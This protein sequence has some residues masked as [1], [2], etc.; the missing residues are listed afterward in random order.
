MLFPNQPSRNKSSVLTNRRVR[1]NEAGGPRGSMQPLEVGGLLPPPPPKPD[2]K[3]KSTPRSSEKGGEGQVIIPNSPMKNQ[4]KYNMKNHEKQSVSL[5]KLPSL[6]GDDVDQSEDEESQN[7]DA[8]FEA[9][10]LGN[11]RKQAGLPDLPDDGLP[12]ASATKMMI[13]DGSINRLVNQP[14]VNL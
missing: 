14:I 8:D 11:L 10:N 4:E 1:W 12:S 5:T 7:P 6:T 2:T 9:D 13:L 3:G